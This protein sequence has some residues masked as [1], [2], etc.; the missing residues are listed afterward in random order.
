MFK[1]R[2]NC[3]GSV[4]S[5]LYTSSVC[6]LP[7]LFCII[8]NNFLLFS[9]INL[10]KYVIHM[11]VPFQFTVNKNCYVFTTFGVFS[12]PCHKYTI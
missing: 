11:S 4:S 2:N 7:D 9:V 1:L 5:V 3:T 6:G 12:F 8:H 10:V